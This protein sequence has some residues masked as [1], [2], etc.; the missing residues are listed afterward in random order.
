MCKPYPKIVRK[1]L[2]SGSTTPATVYRT[3]KKN[4]NSYLGRPVVFEGCALGKVSL[5]LLERHNLAGVVGEQLAP[6][7]LD[8]A[9]ELEVGQV[10]P[11]HLLALQLQVIRLAL[12]VEERDVLDAVLDGVGDH[13]LPVDAEESALVAG[14]ALLQDQLLVTEVEELVEF[15]GVLETHDEVLA[16]E[17]LLAEGA[18]RVLEVDL[19]EELGLGVGEIVGADAGAGVHLL[20]QHLQ[21]F[22]EKFS[23]HHSEKYGSV[24]EHRHIK[25][26]LNLKNL[27]LVKLDSIYTYVT[28]SLRYYQRKKSALAKKKGVVSFRESYLCC[29]W[30][31]YFQC[32]GSEIFITDLDSQ[33]ENQEFRNRILESRGNIETESYL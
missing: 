11:L 8:L 2:G 19:V 17:G 13:G 7:T 26:F 29:P 23:L 18:V 16:G 12:E 30:D 24:A 1:P 22:V 25:P 31:S 33:I 20:G 28:L 27:I 21:V 6:D 15:S 3:F 5:D 32:S 4:R 14:V 10:P 9:A